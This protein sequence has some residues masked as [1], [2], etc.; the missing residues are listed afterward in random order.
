MTSQPPKAVGTVMFYHLTRSSVATTLRAILPR[1]LQAGW[2]VLL[3]GDDRRLAD[4]DAA[5][6][7]GEA[8]EFLPHARAGGTQDADQP[9]LLG[10]GPSAGFDA[11]A[12][13][14]PAALEMAEAAPLQ[15]VWVLFNAEDDAEM[16][17]ARALW[18]EVSAAGLH[19]QYWSEE[20]GKWAL[21]TAA[22]APA[23]P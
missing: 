1:A 20:A 12:L 16:T 5:L 4:L 10:N 23:K 18:K 8:A 19:T 21:K 14:G 6:W 11:M 15:R 9:I 17:A 2:R 3:R 13:V 7:E 22:N